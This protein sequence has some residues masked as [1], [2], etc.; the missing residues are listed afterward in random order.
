MSFS[1]L[2]VACAIAS[3][4]TAA[5]AAE[6]ASASIINRQGQTVGTA[7]LIEGPHGVL[8]H[9]T[10]QGLPPGPKGIHI[11]SVGTCDDPDQGFVASKAHLNPDGKKHGLMNPE[12]PDAGDLPNIFVHAD[13]TVEVELYTSLASLGGQGGRAKILDDDGAAL[14]IHENRDDHAAQP[15]GGAG[16]RLFCGLIKAD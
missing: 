3:A 9:L 2:I 6:Q 15:I 8:I 12:G 11:H 1:R 13:G 14:V 10:A 5:T 16:A 4:A 7:T